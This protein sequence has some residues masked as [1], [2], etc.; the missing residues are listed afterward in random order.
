M[1]LLEFMTAVALWCGT[2]TPERTPIKIDN[3]RTQ[4][5]TCIGKELATKGNKAV[6]ENCF[7]DTVLTEAPSKK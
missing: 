4:L 6:P 3:C 1:V 5:L 2:V 7:L